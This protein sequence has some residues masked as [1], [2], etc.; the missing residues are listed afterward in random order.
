MPCLKVTKTLAFMLSPPASRPSLAGGAEH[1]FE[2]L[3]DVARI[4]LWIEAHPDGFACQVAC[5]EGIFLDQV[6]ERRPP[7]PG[8]HCQSLHDFVGLHA[9]RALTHQLQQDRKSVV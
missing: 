8:R 1:P 2:D 5:N 4:R 7:L 9:R 6:L 3:R